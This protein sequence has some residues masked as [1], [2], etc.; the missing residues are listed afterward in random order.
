MWIQIDLI[1][2]VTCVIIE[3]PSNRGVGLKNWKDIRDD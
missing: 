1:Q 2:T 3:V